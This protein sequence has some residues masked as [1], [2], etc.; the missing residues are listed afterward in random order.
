MRTRILWL[1]AALALLCACASA[2]DMA[3]IDAATAGTV[4]MT[5]PYFTVSCPAEGIVT[6][7]VSDDHGALCYERR[8]LSDDGLFVSDAVYL[9]LQEGNTAYTVEITSESGTWS[10]SLVRTMGYLSGLHASAGTYPF[11]AAAGRPSDER[12]MLVAAV[13][14]TRSFPLV[15]GSAWEVGTVICTVEDG[16]LTVSVQ[17]N[18]GVTGGD[19]DVEVAL[20][21]YEI[22]GL[23]DAGNGI[24]C[25]AAGE[26]IDLENAGAVAVW[27]GMTVSFNPAL[28]LNAPEDGPGDQDLLWRRMVDAA[29]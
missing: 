26:P 23:T 2:E 5:E 17:L 25:A 20:H 16:Q 21:A 22:A 13:D 8:A 29:R 6:M 27:V 4:V 15:A 10:F 24:R 18:E 1:L 19:A 9:P 11:A 7:T 3:V 14:G 12:I 28:C